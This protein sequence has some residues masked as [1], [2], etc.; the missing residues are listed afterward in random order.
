MIKYIEKGKL[1]SA[2]EGAEPDIMAD[3]GE[4]YGSKWGFSHA[5]LYEIIEELPTLEWFNAEERLPRE[6]QMCLLYTPVD[7]YVCVGFYDWADSWNGKKKWK[8]IT[9][10]RSTQT[11]TKKVTH[12]MPLPETPKGVIK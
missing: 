10:M 12:W 11:L 5:K 4:N 3:Y 9:A 7:G 1:L 2:I 6:R 8:L